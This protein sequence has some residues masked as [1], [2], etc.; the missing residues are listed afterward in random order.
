MK[1]RLSLPSAR[2]NAF[3]LRD[4]GSPLRGA[5][6]RGRAIGNCRGRGPRSLWAWSLVQGAAV[7][8]PRQNLPRRF[9]RALRR[10]I[11]AR[12]FFALRAIPSGCY[13]Y[14]FLFFRF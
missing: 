9:R 12:L 6:L 7:F 14:F 4:T 2:K 10:D 1:A 3:R 13:F 5:L 8:S 11:S